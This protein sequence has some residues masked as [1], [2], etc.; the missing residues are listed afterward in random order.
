MRERLGARFPH[1]TAVIDGLLR[2]LERNFDLDRAVI[3]LRPTIL[4]GAPGT[5][6]T[7][8]LRA[9]AAELGLSVSQKSVAGINDSNLFGT[10]AGWSTA[11][12]SIVSSTI[13]QSGT[14][15]PLIILDEIDKAQTT[16]NGSIQ[17][18][19]LPLLEPGEARRYHERYLASAVDASGIN[20]IFSANELDRI[21]FRTHSQ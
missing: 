15:N 19:L 13:A 16:H 3:S 1:A 10:S 6:K 8:L 14:L 12:P 5:G 21:R 4:V 7:A 2:P 9:F 17:E 11:M 20:W 18:C